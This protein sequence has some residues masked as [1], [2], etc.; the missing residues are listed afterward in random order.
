MSI[1]SKEVSTRGWN[2]GQTEFQGNNLV[3]NVGNKVAFD[4]P[5]SE[6]TNTAMPTKNE[7][8][9]EIKPPTEEQLADS[10]DAKRCDQLSE[11]RFFIPGQA[12]TTG[13]DDSFE[14]EDIADAEEFSAAN[15]FYEAI[16]VKADLGMVSAEAIVPFHEMPFITPRGRYEVEMFDEFMRMHG[17]TYDYKIMY[18]SIKHLFLVPKPDDVHN[19]FVIGLDPPVRQGQTRYPYLVLQ[20]LRDEELDV[21]L[22][23]DK[24]EL[25]SRFN[26]KLKKTYDAEISNVV[27]EVFS[28]ISGVEVTKTSGFKSRHGNAG[29]KCAIKANEGHLYPL[30]DGLIFLPKPATYMPFKDISQVIFSRMGPTGSSKTFDQKV[31]MKNG[32]EVSFSGLDKEE[33][34]QLE[35][36]LRSK[37]VKVKSE[38]PVDEI[39]FKKFA[40]TG[41][42]NIGE[43]LEDDEESEDED[44]VGGDESDVAEEFDEEYS[45]DNEDS[46]DR[47]DANDDSE[48]ED[49]DE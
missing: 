27:S 5:L 25:E 11:V 15:F 12:E 4:L 22:N 38:I 7:V 21:T 40:E 24:D 31:M 8:T 44:F 16:K 19:L 26:G 33:Y 41:N 9:L 10:K 2:W 49:D 32:T 46:D 20:F 36:F 30:A 6:V 43:E 45:S 3:F 48:E 39:E 28:A 34:D 13:Q 37:G 35:L 29:M 17:K 42:Q 23:L 18:Q 14:D 47:S 1:E